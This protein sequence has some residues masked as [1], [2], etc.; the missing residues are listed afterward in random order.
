MDLVLTV[1]SATISWSGTPLSSTL[2]LTTIVVEG[3]LS[4]IILSAEQSEVASLQRYFKLAT[5]AQ[6]RSLSVGHATLDIETDTIPTDVYCAYAA[7]IR[8]GNLS[9]NAS[10]CGQHIVLLLQPSPAM[11]N[12]H[13]QGSASGSLNA[14]AGKD[15]GDIV[16]L[17]RILA[18]SYRRRF[19]M[20]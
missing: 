16:P 6:A 3:S 20:S 7:T 2:A 4:R 15:A 19:N 11:D 1:C 18:E 14:G 9:R 17:H 5:E 10:L 8:S 13:M 12:T